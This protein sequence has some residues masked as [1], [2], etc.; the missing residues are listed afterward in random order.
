MPPPDTPDQ[1]RVAIIGAGWAGLAAAH[2]LQQKNF[3]VHVFEQSHTLGGRARKVHSRKLGRTIDNG[4]HLLIGAY[5]DTLRL[6]QE[7]GLSD[8]KH[9]LWHTLDF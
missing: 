2:T 5:V 6:M 4:Q 8:K 9:F 3:K 1:K 7:L